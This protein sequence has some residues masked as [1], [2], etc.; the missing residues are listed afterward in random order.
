[1]TIAGVT[2]IGFGVGYFLLTLAGV[3][4]L[5]ILLR[6]K[7]IQGPWLLFAIFV[8]PAVVTG[9]SIKD[10]WFATEGIWRWVRLILL[11]SWAP[12]VLGFEIRNKF[13]YATQVA[14]WTFRWT[15]CALMLGFSIWAFGKAERGN[16]VQAHV[17]AGSWYWLVASE[18]GEDGYLFTRD[19][20]GSLRSQKVLDSVG[21]D[22]IYSYAI[23]WE[24][25]RMQVF[26]SEE[27][28]PQGKPPIQHT[29][30]TPAARPFSPGDDLPL[31][32][33]E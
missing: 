28:T 9:L 15:L 8:I 14:K 4:M 18:D 21:G 7:S 19:E 11:F 16:L 3:I 25:D 2:L 13:L 22:G 31:S 27:T 10:P 33:P 26:L 32:Q 17:H 5:P 30:K 12:V 1:M 20:N 24:N 6:R 29:S 23:R